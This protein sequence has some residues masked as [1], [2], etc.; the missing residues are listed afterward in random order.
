MRVLS[1]QLTPKEGE[2]AAEGQ[3]SQTHKRAAR[4]LPPHQLPTSPCGP[5]R[6]LCQTHLLQHTSRRLILLGQ[7]HRVTQRHQERQTR[8]EGG[9][10]ARQQHHEDR[11]RV[12]EAHRE[13]GKGERSQCEPEARTA[14]DPSRELPSFL[15]TPPQPTV[16][17][18]GSRLSP[19]LPREYKTRRLVSRG[20]SLRI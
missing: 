10:W 15:G 12:G 9:E 3:L 6:G 5:G 11:G 4:A 18:R 1:P 19:P 8:N 14:G 17:R 7:R 2:A 20:L 13:I 16:A